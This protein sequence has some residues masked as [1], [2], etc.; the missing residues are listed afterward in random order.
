MICQLEKKGE[1]RRLTLKRQQLRRKL[2]RHFCQPVHER[3]YGTF[4]RVVDELDEVRRKIVLLKC[5]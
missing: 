4:E 3:D 1:L 5:R 2:K